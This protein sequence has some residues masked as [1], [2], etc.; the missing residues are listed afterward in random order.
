MDLNSSN[1]NVRFGDPEC[2]VLMM[3]LKDDLLVLLN[4]AVDG[5][6]GHNVCALASD[7]A[8]LTVVMAAPGYPETPQKVSAIAG[9]EKV[10]DGVEVFHAGTR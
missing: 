7:E 4:A 8:A 9:L 5:Q 6:L 2:Q 1:Y 3:R 10:P